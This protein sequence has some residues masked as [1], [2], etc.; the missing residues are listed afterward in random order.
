[1]VSILFIWF[2][3][4]LEWKSCVAKDGAINGD[5]LR[6]GWTLCC[7]GSFCFFYLW[8][9]FLI[10]VVFCFLWAFAPQFHHTQKRMGILW[11]LIYVPLLRKVRGVGSLYHSG[12]FS[13]TSWEFQ[14]LSVQSVP[15][16][17][18]EINET[19]NLWRS[20]VDPDL[21]IA[22]SFG[23][24]DGHFLNFALC[25]CKEIRHYFM[26]AFSCSLV[27]SGVWRLPYE[28]ASSYSGYSG[29]VLQIEIHYLN[30]WGFRIVEVFHIRSK[31]GYYSRLYN[32]FPINGTKLFRYKTMGFGLKAL[33]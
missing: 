32:I 25:L 20:I 17:V 5:S 28:Y 29:Q 13:A 23:E 19:W 33:S 12:R 27:V 18:E 26:V 11:E 1:M 10:V 7:S 4:I 31:M 3:T 14:A 9:G 15:T 8:V 30:S 24:Y 2:A 16:L 22:L 21:T 6:S